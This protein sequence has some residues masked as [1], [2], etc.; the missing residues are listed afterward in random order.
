MAAI[1]LE[2]AVPWPPSSVPSARSS[3]AR[4]GFARARVV[5]VLD[6]LPD[7]G[8]RNVEVWWMAGMTEP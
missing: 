7:R 6:E 4:V 2:N 3:A 5:V 8:W 1:P